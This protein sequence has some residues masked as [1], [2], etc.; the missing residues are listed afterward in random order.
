MKVG[1]QQG[2]VFSPFLFV[3]LMDVLTEDVRDGSL[4]EFFY[5]DKFICVDNH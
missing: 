4:M 2:S 5:A 1:L 3:M